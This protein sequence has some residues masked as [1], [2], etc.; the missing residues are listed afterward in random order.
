[1]GTVLIYGLGALFF[2]G[3]AG[4]RG[5]LDPPAKA[6]AVALMEL[7]RLTEFGRQILSVGP[8]G[9]RMYVV[10]ACIPTPRPRRPHIEMKAAMRGFEAAQYVYGSREQG[11]APTITFTDKCEI[12]PP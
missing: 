4:F 2:S 12:M 10:G 11:V 9:I 1:M 3:C 8:A 7:Q 5:P 6:E